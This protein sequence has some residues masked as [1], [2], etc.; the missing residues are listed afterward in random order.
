MSR[1]EINKEEP[2]QKTCSVC[3]LTARN[4]D[5]LED[6]VYHAHRQDR[7]NNANAVSAEQK[8]DP[9]FET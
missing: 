4:K 5:E 3:G 8:I 6:H 2:K 1:R 9:F 7:A